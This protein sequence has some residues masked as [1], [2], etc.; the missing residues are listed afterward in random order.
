MALYTLE[1]DLPTLAEPV[2]IAA[3]DGW[4]DA[5]AA[6]SSA[7]E[8]LTTG[9]KVIARFDTD[10]LYDY[11]SRRP[12][13][14]VVDGVLSDLSWPELCCATPTWRVATC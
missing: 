14:D 5:A 1:S 12:L 2:I 6:A 13:L 4:V 11:R 7:I 8:Q 10:A 3:F 9:A